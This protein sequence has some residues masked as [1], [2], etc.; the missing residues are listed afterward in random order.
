MAA[1]HIAAECAFPEDLSQRMLLL[2]VLD[3]LALKFQRN[4]LLD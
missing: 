4:L 2:I 3:K 1:F